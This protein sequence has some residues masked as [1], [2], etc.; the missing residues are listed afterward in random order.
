MACWMLRFFHEITIFK[1]K[2]GP[3][4]A[5][6]L[7]TYFFGN[8]YRTYIIL[9]NIQ[10]FL[11]KKVCTYCYHFFLENRVH[12]D[13]CKSIC[14][15]KV[16]RD[17]SVVMPSLFPYIRNMVTVLPNLQTCYLCMEKQLA[18]PPSCHQP[19]WCRKLNY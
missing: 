7:S 19:P 8:S 17:K 5:Q 14:G 15:L 13:I 2:W 10:T 16:T 11:V 3:F 1:E 9:I 18:M 6:L 4:C 12:E